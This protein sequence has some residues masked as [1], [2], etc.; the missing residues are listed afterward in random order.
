MASEQVQW[1]KSHIAQ[2]RAQAGVRDDFY[3]VHAARASL[4]PLDLELP[5][6]LATQ[7]IEAGQ[8]RMRWL[9]VPG[10]DPDRRIVYLHGGGY[11]AGGYHSHGPMLAWLAHEARAAVLYVDYRLAPEARFP[12]GLDDACQA[13]DLAFA[14]GPAGT[15]SAGRPSVFVGGDSAGGGLAIGTLLRRR[16]AGQ[17]AP[18]AAFSLCGMLDLDES[19]SKFL[20]SSQRTRDSARLVVSHLKD[21]QHPYLS[22]VRADLAGLPPLLLQ[23]GSEDY[24]REDSLVLAERARAAGV[25]VTLQVWPAMFHVWQRFAPKVPEALQALR[26]VADFLRLHG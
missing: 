4:Q 22:V 17:P 6:G 21:L 14:R 13:V 7:D 26:E 10:A 15:P 9:T 23:T 25:D 11:L 8:L 18:A 2:A 3:D 5:A 24:C 20:Q 16:D 12:A 19:S 1:A